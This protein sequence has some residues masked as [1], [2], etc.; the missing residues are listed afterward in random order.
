[1]ALF[2]GLAGTTPEAAF[3]V[4]R[5]M[6]NVDELDATV[7]LIDA[8]APAAA[9][10]TVAVPAVTP[11]TVTERIP[12]TSVVPAPGVRDTVPLPVWVSVTATFGIGEPPASF[13]VIVN[14]TGD[15]PFEGNDVP[16]AVNETVEPTIWTGSNAEAVPPAA[17]MVAVRLALLKVP[18]ENVAVALP[19]ASVVT[20]EVLRRP[21]SALKVILASGTIA[22]V[23]LT[24]VTVIVLEFELSDLIVVGE[25]DI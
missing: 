1:M 24:A 6:P 16:D 12:F 13:V 18:E 5:L 19:V 11:A 21:V 20:V 22:L 8:V 23:A 4:T 2:L 3:S 15:V 7:K 9:T 25:P 10:V 14:V 17:V